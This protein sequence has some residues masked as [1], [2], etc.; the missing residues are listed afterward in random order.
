M[1]VMRA[2]HKAAYAFVLCDN[3][4]L[5]GSNGRINPVLCGRS[6]LRS[7]LMKRLFIATLVVM[8]PAQS[9]AQ[10]AEAQVGAQQSPPGLPCRSRPMSLGKAPP[11]PP[12]PYRWV[13]M[14]NRPAMPTSTRG[15]MVTETHPHVAHRRPMAMPAPVNRSAPT[16][17]LPHSTGQSSRGSSAA[18]RRRR[19]RGSSIQRG[20]RRFQVAADPRKGRP[21]R[22]R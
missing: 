19:P 8:V 2:D 16:D 9:W 18:V 13:G 15:P 14:L 11:R 1:K 7:E 20:K 10:R 21:R 17:I 6:M 5:R 4:G 22:R 3:I 12:N